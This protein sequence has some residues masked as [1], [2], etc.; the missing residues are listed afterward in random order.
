MKSTT[1][2]KLITLACVSFL[3]LSPQTGHAFEN[4]GEVRRL[5]KQFPVDKISDSLSNKLESAEGVTLAERIA[6]IGRVTNEKK[7]YKELGSLVDHL[8]SKRGLKSDLIAAQLLMETAGQIKKSNY[9]LSND[10][11]NF[12]DELC[13]QAARLL[14]HSNP[15]VQATAEWMLTLRVKNQDSSGRKVHELFLNGNFSPNWY[16]QWQARDKALFLQD[17]YARQLIQFGQHFTV[18]GVSSAVETN[19]ENLKKLI[20]DPETN[21]SEAAVTAY[22]RALNAARSAVAQSDLDKAHWAYLRVRSAGRELIRSSRKDFP[23]EGITFFTNPRIT[24]GVWNVNVPVVGHTNPPYGDLYLK[25]T[26]DVDAPAVPLLEGKLGDGSIRG[27]DLHWDSDKILFSWW[28]QPINGTE[29]FGWDHRLNAGLYELDLSTGQVVQRTEQPGYNDIEPCYLPDGGFVFASDRSSY[30]NQCAGPILQ[31]KRCTT[32][33]RYDPA[34][35]DVPIAISNNKDFDRHPSVLN[36]GTIAFMHWEYQER[37]LYTSHNVWRSRPDGI[38]MDAYYKQHISSPMSIRTVRQIPGSELHVATAQG[39]HDAHNGPIILFNPSLGINNEQAMWLVTP[40]VTPVEGGLGPLEKQVVPEGG[41]QNRGGSYISPFPMSEKVF[42][43]GHDI[44]G[45]ESE[46]SIYYIDVWG[47][48]ELLHRDR[49]MSSFQPFALRKRETPPVVADM[50]RPEENYAVA[51]LEDV[52]R[53][54]PG[55]EKGAVKY[56]RMSQALMLPAPTIKEDGTWDYN[57]LHY[58][59]G[60]ATARH[61]GHW[62]WAP[63]R[64]IGLVDVEPD[65]S[66]YFKVPAGTPVYLQAL[67]ENFCEVQRMRTSFTLQRGEI[68]SCTGCHETRLETVGNRKPM[69]QTL[70]A[71]GPQHPEPPSWGINTVLDYEHD[72]QPILDRNCTDC[73]GQDDPAGGIELTD[74]KV[75]GFNQ[76]YRTLFGLSPEDPLPTNR[77]RKW[78]EAL[79]P[80]AKGTEYVEKREGDRILDRMQ[81]NEYP[82]QLIMISDRMGDSSITPPL[83]FG[84]NRSPLI[85][86]IVQ[87]PDYHRGVKDRLTDEEWLKLVTWVDHNAVYHGTLLDVR[88]FKEIGKFIR[89]PYELPNPWEEPADLNPTFKNSADNLDLLSIIRR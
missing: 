8:L 5:K 83:A 19:F 33:F 56:L 25:K 86:S 85:Q 62:T 22:G 28:T 9:G 45:N 55:V 81:R 76:S 41:V 50:V 46:F 42:L 77:G 17:D 32:L 36:D 3:A 59:P 11:K 65:G 18:E 16:G 40:G 48:R 54:L 72:I 66:A 47:N 10:I 75:A 39:H 79:Y 53:D 31:N 37:G 88:H 63:R 20:D 71:R 26:T 27:T 60:D 52:Y 15:V 13:E 73:H 7:A 35:A 6:V 43:A 64:T 21:A 4:E 1:Y 68:R 78:H 23:S 84:S 30:G 70:L 2:L 80:D 67:D 14:D 57:H 49:D 51:F 29:P 82:G 89:V 12:P 44:Y 61:F 38:N 74:R 87:Q 58:L 24:G 34:R 69:P